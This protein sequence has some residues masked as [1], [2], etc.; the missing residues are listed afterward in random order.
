MWGSLLLFWTLFI[1][2]IKPA[3]R[4]IVP[5]NQSLSAVEVGC[6]LDERRTHFD[7][8]CHVL[9]RVLLHFL[10]SSLVFLSPL[11][12]Q[13][14]FIPPKCFSSAACHLCSFVYYSGRHGK[15]CIQRRSLDTFLLS[16]TVK[17]LSIVPPK[18]YSSS[19]YWF[20]NS[21]ER[22][23]VITCQPLKCQ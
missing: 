18:S 1:C 19:S 16:V 10:F 12:S 3:K 5:Q 15:R 20:C 6:D 13:L 14:F 7:L 11:F 21:Y 22:V 23:P 9:L 2:V 17:L 4:W 8:D